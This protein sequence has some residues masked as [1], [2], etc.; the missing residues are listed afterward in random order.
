M[1]I[2]ISNAGL[3][4]RLI[5]AGFSEGVFTNELG[6]TMMLRGRGVCGCG[7]KKMF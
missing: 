4:H 1:L 2:I 6:V 5:D 3:T 7:A